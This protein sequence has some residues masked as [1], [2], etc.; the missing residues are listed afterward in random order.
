VGA[1]SFRVGAD[2]VFSVTRTGPVTLRVFDL[3]GR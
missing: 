3:E 2:V 1:K